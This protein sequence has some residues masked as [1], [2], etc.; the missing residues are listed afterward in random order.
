MAAESGSGF[1]VQ[2]GNGGDPQVYTTI[3]GLRATSMTFNNQAIDITNKDSGAW[4]ELLSG[5]GVRRISVSGSGVFTNSAAET[6]VR[7]KAL[8]AEHAPLKLIFA[9][10][11]SFTGDF[12]VVSLEYAG[13]FNGERTYALSMESS[14]MIAF[15]S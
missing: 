7:T 10:G 11:D 12:Q 14:G 4:R 15:S 5:A 9:N 2:I 8:A 13:D 1:L 6:T 3:A